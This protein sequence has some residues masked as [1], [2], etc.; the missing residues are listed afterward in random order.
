MNYMQ[1]NINWNTGM[2][3]CKKIIIHRHHSA[4]FSCLSIN[5][6]SV[7]IM[8]LCVSLSLITSIVIFTIHLFT[9]APVYAGYRGGE[10]TR[11]WARPLHDINGKFAAQ[12]IR[13]GHPGENTLLL[14]LSGF[15]PGIYS[16]TLHFRGAVGRK[17]MVVE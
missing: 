5:P 7:A 3:R 4:R 14:D 10:I 1:M 8:K 9:T 16:Y 11:E 13:T 2:W 6:L 15:A 17:A 12:Q